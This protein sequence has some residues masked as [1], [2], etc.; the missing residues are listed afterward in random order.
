MI[1]GMTISTEALNTLQRVRRHE[2]VLALQANWMIGIE[3]PSKLVIESMT[4]VPAA[5]VKLDLPRSRNGATQPG[6]ANRCLSGLPRNGQHLVVK[7]YS[8]NAEKR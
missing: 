7:T 6:Y 3:V 2:L 1:S 5:A 4:A 8:G